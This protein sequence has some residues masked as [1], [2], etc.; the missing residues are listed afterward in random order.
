[1][2]QDTWP[3]HLPAHSQGESDPEAS[4]VSGYAVLVLIQPRDFLSLPGLHAWPYLS[5]T[6]N[7]LCS[8]QSNY[9]SHS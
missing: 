9:L 6:H 5:D 7:I 1:M 4:V 3:G 8:H 2:T